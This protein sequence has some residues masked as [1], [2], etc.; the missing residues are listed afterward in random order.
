M[1]EY[2][3]Q[4]HVSYEYVISCR[5]DVLLYKD[6]CLSKYDPS[7]IYVNDNEKADF[8]HV[9]NFQNS[10]SFA[11]LYQLRKL[12]HEHFVLHADDIKHGINEEVLRKLKLDG[13]DRH[14]LHTSQFYKYG[15]TDENIILLTH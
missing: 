7:R 11:N 12:P 6:L 10:I 15:L 3:W 5:L 14:C 1:H 8:R 9:M 2:V 13:I 4:E